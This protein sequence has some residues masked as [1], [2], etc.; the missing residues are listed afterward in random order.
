MRSREALKSLL[1]ATEQMELPMNGPSAPSA[2]APQSVAPAEPVRPMKP[3]KYIVGSLRGMDIEDLYSPTDTVMVVLHGVI[4]DWSGGV[5]LRHKERVI[6]VIGSDTEKDS[7]GP[8]GQKCQIFV[9]NM[10][11]GRGGRR[12]LGGYGANWTIIGYAPP[13]KK[14]AREWGVRAL[15]HFD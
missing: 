2:E 14:A 11:G 6:G 12:E 3:E 7:Y 9:D 4:E 10:Q 15:Y 1:E 13:T 5:G 8:K